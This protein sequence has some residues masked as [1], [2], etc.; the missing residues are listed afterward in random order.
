MYA[1]AVGAD[2]AGV[3]DGGPFRFIYGDIHTVPGG[4]IEV[5]YIR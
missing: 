2:R 1:V 3:P 4:A 5:I